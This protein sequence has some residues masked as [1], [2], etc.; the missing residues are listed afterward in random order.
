MEG[1]EGGKEG[2]G[3]REGGR[4][5][6]KN[7]WGPD[8]ITAQASDFKKPPSVI[9][10]CSRVEAASDWNSPSTASSDLRQQGVVA[11]PITQ[12]YNVLH[13]ESDLTVHASI[14]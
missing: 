4:E 5:E 9:L 11:E 1:R 13:L 3:V 14:S 7:H 8:F 12:V 10:M 2:G 6:R